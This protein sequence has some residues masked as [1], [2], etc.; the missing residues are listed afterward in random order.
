MLRTLR[1]LRY[2]PSLLTG[3]AVAAVSATVA[4]K[5]LRPGQA[6]LV[7]WDMGVVAYVLAFCR[8]MLR[9]S[10]N[11]LQQV[12]TRF[13]EGRWGMLLVTVGAALA[14]LGA[15]VAEL[16]RVH[17]T[18]HAGWTEA[19]AAATVILSWMFVHTIFATH[20]AHEYWRNAK[21]LSFPGNETPGISEFLYFSFCIAVAS[22]VSDVSTESAAMRQLVLAHSMIAY[23]FNTAIIALGVN[24]AA[25][26][27]S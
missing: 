13:D 4:L 23:L 16:A 2:R 15:I 26:L 11:D 6:A 27:A 9:S 5:F 18:S 17:G 7:A 19:L 20:Y 22:Q 3:M 1:H 21:G 10:H 24:I 12:A 25:S 14:S 8:V